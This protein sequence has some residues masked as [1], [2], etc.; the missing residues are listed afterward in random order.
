MALIGAYSCSNRQETVIEPLK[1]NSYDEV[2]LVEFCDTVWKLSDLFGYQIPL[3]EI[4]KIR[5]NSDAIYLIEHNLFSSATLKKIDLKNKTITKIGQVGKGPEEY[6]DCF[7]FSVLPNGVIA[8]FDNT[9]NKLNYYNS[10]GKFIRTFSIPFYMVQFEFID[11]SSFIALC[12][13]PHEGRIMAYNYYTKQK[14]FSSDKM[15]N[16]D[17]DFE[18]PKVFT[19]LNDT[20][21]YVIPGDNTVY[22]FCNSKAKPY[23]SFDFN[24]HNLDEK[25]YKLTDFNERNHY[26]IKNELC[27]ISQLHK[28]SNFFFINFLMGNQN[29]LLVIKGR[30]AIATIKSFKYEGE[31][32]DLPISIAGNLMIFYDDNTGDLVFGKLKNN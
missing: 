1:V 23:I 2:E 25:F 27:I 6:I 4:S 21:F 29:N 22:S 17:E 20:I 9:S 31:S 12:Y 16:E 10:E 24:S 7:D 30:K 5:I 28:T 15:F 18:V 3:G 13:E 8:I 26:F 19:K 14:T 11:T 32:L